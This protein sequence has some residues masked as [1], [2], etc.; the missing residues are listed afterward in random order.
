MRPAPAIEAL[1]GLSFNG[2]AFAADMAM[3]DFGPTEPL[4]IRHGARK[5]ETIL[6][7][8]HGLHVQCAWRLRRGASVLATS[9]GPPRPAAV[10]PA[11]GLIVDNVEAAGGAIVIGLGA[12]RLEVMPGGDGDEQWRLLTR[13]PDQDHLVWGGEYGTAG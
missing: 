11:A 4:T 3:F 9:H 5:G 10:E 8:S 7:G 2:V 13:N 12:F 1:A 6:A